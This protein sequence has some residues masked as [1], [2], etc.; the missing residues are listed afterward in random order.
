M[1]TGAITGY[2]DVAQLVLYAF[3]FFFFALIIYLHREGK[4]EGYPLVDPHDENYRPQG[5]PAVP[6]PKT[7][8][9]PHGQGTRQAPRASN[10]EQREL[11]MTKGSAGYPF[12]PTGD[13]MQDGIG[14]A[15]WAVRPELPDLTYDGKPKIV[16]LRVAEGYTVSTR[17]PDPRGQSVYGVDDEVGATVSDIWVDTSEPQIRYLELDAGGKRVMMPMNFARIKSNGDVVAKS[18]CGRHF[19]DAP[20]T[21]NPDQITLQEEDKIGAYYAGGYL[22]ALRE[23]QEPVL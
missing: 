23:R 8:L 13:P 1:G 9:M 10:D 16:P 21:A 18:V 20:T 17:D 3:W 14:P 19:A 2:I 7:Y 12:E 11:K 15:S 5:F 22:Y 4:R 6:E